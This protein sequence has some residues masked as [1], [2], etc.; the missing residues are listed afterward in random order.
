MD[1]LKT[2]IQDRC[3]ET[4]YAI[5]KKIF[6]FFFFPSLF[7]FS[8]SSG[9][10]QPTM[11]KPASHQKPILKIFRIDQGL[12]STK[13]Q[14][15]L[16]PGTPYKVCKVRRRLQAWFHKSTKR[17]HSHSSFCRTKLCLR[18]IHG[19]N[20]AEACHLIIVTN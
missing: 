1:A 5:W 13:V 16:N 18:L 14:Y 8:H 15:C 6:F 4:C 2:K 3:T 20:Y 10:G 12:A 7:F 17:S 9:H 11:G 19:T